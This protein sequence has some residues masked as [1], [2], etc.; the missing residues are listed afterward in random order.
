MDNFA[1]RANA[2]TVPI[3]AIARKDYKRWLGGQSK[4]T[5]AWL[6]A[7]EFSRVLVPFAVP[8]DSRLGGRS[9]YDARRSMG[10]ELARESP[11]TGDL[12]ASDCVV[13]PALDTGVRACT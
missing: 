9:V 11:P 8:S 10:R 5:Q 12:S 3:T 4:P 7:T 1:T 6:K 2:K 13:I